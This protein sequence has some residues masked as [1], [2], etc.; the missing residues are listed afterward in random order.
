MMSPRY[1]VGFIT[2]QSV[3]GCTGLSTEQQ[4]FQKRT[5]VPAERWLQNNFPWHETYPFPEP[6]QL[7]AASWNNVRGYLASR[8]PAFAEQHRELVI[9]KLADYDTIILLAGSC[10]LEL[11]N[12][13]NLPKDLRARLHVF[14]YGPVSR[15]RPEVASCFIVQGER[16][17]LS[18]FYHRQADRRYPCPH[19]GYLEA[20]ETLTCFNAF[21]REVMGV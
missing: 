20:P 19:M 5:E 17:W 10:G 21:Y 4:A 16:D 15:Q 18:R 2:G 12:N 1:I 3:P 7:L 6:F 13:L 11:L 9:Q 14:A 8:Q